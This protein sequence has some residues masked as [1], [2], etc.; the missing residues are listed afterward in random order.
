MH[1]RLGKDLEEGLPTSRCEEDVALTPK[2]NRLGLVIFEECLP[3]RVKLDVG[4]IIIEEVE[5]YLLCV[6]TFEKMVVHVPV[7]GADQLRFGMSGCVNGVD[8]RR[9]EET[10]DRFLGLRG[11]SLPVIVP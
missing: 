4:P 9:L 5:L 7:I 1:F 11:A 2:D 8:G 6:R 3:L 10:G